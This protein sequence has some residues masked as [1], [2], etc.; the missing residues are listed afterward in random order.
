MR[1]QMLLASAILALPLAFTAC[2]RKVAE[3]THTHEDS[4][5]NVVQEKKVVTESPSGDVTVKKETTESH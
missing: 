3:S 5:G 1:T 2:D 4:N